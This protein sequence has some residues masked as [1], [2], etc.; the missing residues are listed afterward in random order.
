MRDA[1]LTHGL[2]IQPGRTAAVGKIGETPIVAVPG[3][4][5]QALGLC[6]M[7]IQPVLDKL[8]ARAPRTGVVRPLVR[9]I[10]SAVGVAELVL[11][12]ISDGAWM[13]LATGQLSLNSIVD[14]DAWLI[15]PA[16]SEGHAAA[17]ALEAFPLREIL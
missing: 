15:V 13:P 17:T 6:L 3:A 12:K 11:L 8:S 5:D 7:L 1:L 4:S 10:A 16:N 2:A 9:K 14:A